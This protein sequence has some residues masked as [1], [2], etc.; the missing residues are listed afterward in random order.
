MS[1]HRVI[2]RIIAGEVQPQEWI[3]LVTNDSL[4]ALH[5][6]PWVPTECRTPELYLAAL[7]CNRWLSLHFQTYERFYKTKPA[8]K[9]VAPPFTEHQTGTFVFTD[10]D[11]KRIT[12]PIIEYR[13]K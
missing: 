2:E 13:I 9:Y 12:K 4:L 6:L 5:V 8:K 11:G 3:T 1:I 7:G 10:V